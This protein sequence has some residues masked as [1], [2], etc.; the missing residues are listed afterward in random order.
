MKHLLLISL[1]TVTRFAV[2]DVKPCQES[3][4]YYLANASKPELLDQY[5]SLRRRAASNNSDRENVQI[6]IK[7]KREAKLD[8]SPDLD[9]VL[10]FTKAA[11]SCRAAAESVAGALS[12]RFKSKPPSCS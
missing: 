5:C 10:E 8:A 11:R 2:A 3:E 7:E 4:Y 1:L 12:R 9:R 6:T